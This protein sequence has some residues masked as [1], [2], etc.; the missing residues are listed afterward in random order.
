M[1]TA[2]AARPLRQHPPTP[3]P[4]VARAWTSH[5]KTTVMDGNRIVAE[6]GSGSGEYLAACEVDARLIAA[7]PDLLAAVQRLLRAH[8]SDGVS[9]IGD[10]PAAEARRAVAR[11]VG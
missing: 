8:Y 6:C 1:N 4:W 2:E 9:Y 11:A 5:A 10:H 3:E 7:A